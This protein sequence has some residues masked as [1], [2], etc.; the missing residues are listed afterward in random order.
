ML[1]YPP[2][3]GRVGMSDIVD[4]LYDKGI[5]PIPNL[6]YEAADEITRQLRLRLLA[7]GED[8][9]NLPEAGD[10]DQLPDREARRLHEVQEPGLALCN[11][12]RAGGATRRWQRARSGGNGCRSPRRSR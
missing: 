9:E 3:F 7:S 6:H 1:K 5:W 4:S 12:G 8:P 10:L 2:L 11:G